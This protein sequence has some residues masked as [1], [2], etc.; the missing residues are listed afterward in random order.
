MLLLWQLGTW[1]MIDPITCKPVCN[2]RT[3]VASLGR[4]LPP[5]SA[6]GEDPVHVDVHV[7][8]YDEALPPAPVIPM[9][10]AQAG[11][12]PVGTILDCYM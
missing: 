9:S 8:S 7:R 3:E 5:A 10:Q 12:R 6:V 11:Q 1:L 2:D 4:Y